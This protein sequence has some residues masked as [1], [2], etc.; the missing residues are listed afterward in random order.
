MLRVLSVLSVLQIFSSLTLPIEG[1]SSLEEALEQYTAPQLL[2]AGNQLKC[3]H[4]NALTDAETRQMLVELPPYLVIS[5]NRFAFD[6]STY[7]RYKVGD[8]LWLCPHSEL[9]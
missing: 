1:L 2:T 8:K 6:M 5:L 7:Q 3:S 9:G 4:C